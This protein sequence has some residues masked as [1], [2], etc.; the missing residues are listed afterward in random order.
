MDLQRF[1]P[2]DREAILREAEATLRANAQPGHP[3]KLMTRGGDPDLWRWVVRQLADDGWEVGVDI[4]TGDW[5]FTPPEFVGAIY[6]GS[7]N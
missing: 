2:T 1:D 7:R 6:A 5:V 4:A 3:A